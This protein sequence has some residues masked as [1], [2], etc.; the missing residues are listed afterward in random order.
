MTEKIQA[1]VGPQHI[2][3]LEKLEAQTGLSTPQVIRFLIEHAEV[4]QPAKVT[5]SLGKNNS[6]AVSFQA[7][8]A[9][10]A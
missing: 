4:V 5:V 9:A 7:G 10:V 2:K 8:G 1:R 6:D 3:K